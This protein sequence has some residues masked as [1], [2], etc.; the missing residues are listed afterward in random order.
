MHTFVTTSLSLL[1]IPIVHR[2][3]PLSLGYEPRALSAMIY[4]LPLYAHIWLFLMIC[5]I[6]AT[7]KHNGHHS[8]MCFEPL[9]I[10][11]MSFRSFPD[12]YDPYRHFAM[13]L[14]YFRWLLASI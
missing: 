1:T 5:N 3:I 14:C 13:F 10:Y 12:S 8:R 4:M 7:F 6:C 2:L 11:A 9:G